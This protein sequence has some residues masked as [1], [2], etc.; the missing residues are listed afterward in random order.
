MHEDLVGKHL[1]PVVGI[2][3]VISK[4]DGIGRLIECIRTLLDPAAKTN[5]ID[6]NSSHSDDSSPQA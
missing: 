1:L 6:H 4:S 5:V 2:D 3:A